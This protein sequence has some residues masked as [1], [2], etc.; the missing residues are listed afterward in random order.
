[1]T[2]IVVDTPP[3]VILWSEAQHVSTTTRETNDLPRI[4]ELTTR[5]NGDF[6]DGTVGLNGHK[7]SPE[8]RLMISPLLQ[9]PSEVLYS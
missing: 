5:I 1:M 2:T 6:L 4:V 7:D 3:I 8:Q 9:V